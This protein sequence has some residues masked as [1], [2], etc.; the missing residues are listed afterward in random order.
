MIVNLDCF[1]VFYYLQGCASG[2]HL[3]QGVWRQLVEEIMPQ[4]DDNE[5]DAIWWWM[6]RDLWD[7]FNKPYGDGFYKCGNEDFNHA[8]A[9][10]HRNNYAMISFFHPDKKWKH[11]RIQKCYRYNDTFYV[12]GSFTK[13][14]PNEW[15][16]SA[17]WV[18]PSDNEYVERS[19]I[20]LWKNDKY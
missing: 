18:A 3:R 14:I 19:K 4:M 15:I 1:E 2:S 10:L 17:N 11:P 6:R 13:F 9:A 5:K 7:I 12:E 20:E 16:I 8:M